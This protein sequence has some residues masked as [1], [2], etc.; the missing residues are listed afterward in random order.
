MSKPNLAS[1]SA[2][3]SASLVHT[4][5]LSQPEYDELPQTRATRLSVLAI[6]NRAMFIIK[7]IN[8]DKVFFDFLYYLIH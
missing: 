3:V 8:S 1:L 4:G 6:A 7:M 5:K 2:I